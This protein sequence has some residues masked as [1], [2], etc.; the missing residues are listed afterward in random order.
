MVRSVLVSL[1]FLCLLGIA[2]VFA[3]LNPGR[4]RLDLAFG[5]VEVEQS[6]ALIGALAIG[7]IIGVLC[8]GVALLRLLQQRRSLRRALRLAEQEVQA[9]R[10][11]PTRDAD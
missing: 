10:S 6:L 5:V 11:I 2:A 1:L 7:W 3:A 8:V 4:I 9:L